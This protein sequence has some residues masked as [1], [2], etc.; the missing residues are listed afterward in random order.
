MT[1][2]TRGAPGRL[3]PWP[4][5]ILVFG[6]CVAGCGDD[7]TAPNPAQPSAGSG[8]IAGQGGAGAGGAGAGGAGAGGA[9]ASGAGAGGDA[10]AAG[11]GLSFSVE[12]VGGDA[13]ARLPF[14]ATPDP[15]GTAVYFTGAGAEGNGVFKVVL[16]SGT[17]SEVF[18][19]EPFAAPVGIAISDDGTTLFLADPAAESGAEDAGQIFSLSTSG[20]I[21]AALAGGSGKVP[22]GLDVRGNKIYFSGKGGVYS[23]PTSGGQATTLAEGA[24]LVDPVGIAAN[25][26]GE[27][28]VLDSAAAG[29]ATL[30][31]V[32]GGAVTV[33]VEGLGV[34]FPAGIALS[35][36]EKAVLVS[37]VDPA[38]GKDV[39]WVVDVTTGKLTPFS[40]TIGQFTEAAGLHRAK[41]KELF[42]WADSK[43]NG[44]G[45]VFVLQKK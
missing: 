10:G 33:L 13:S 6:A 45:T 40:D 25:A 37:A 14:D 4:L 42:A 8:G 41:N 24:P 31:K 35:L 19:G 12:A 39:V 30:F 28:F 38:T 26:A 36:D 21:P 23:L 7:D 27:V 22:R 5:A 15:D 3:W 2:T 11:S 17:K 32:A 16:A 44:T 20:G 1:R 34:G 18:V 29:G 9:G 43:A